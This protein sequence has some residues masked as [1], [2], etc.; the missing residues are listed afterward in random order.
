MVSCYHVKRL[1]SKLG[2]ISESGSQYKC[3]LINNPNDDMSHLGV[4]DENHPVHLVGFLPLLVDQG[5]LH[6]QPVDPTT[7]L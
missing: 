4:T 1:G 6:V 5:E 3:I 2:Q 7:T